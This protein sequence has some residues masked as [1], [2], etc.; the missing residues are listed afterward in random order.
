MR[1]YQGTLAGAIADAQLLPKGFV[2]NIAADGSDARRSQKI[3]NSLQ[4]TGNY[5]VE[6]LSLDLK[7]NAAGG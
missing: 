1:L 6:S 3:Y 5:T 2:Y 4:L 7:T